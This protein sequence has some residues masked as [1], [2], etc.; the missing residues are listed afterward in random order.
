MIASRLQARAF[1]AGGASLR[2]RSMSF[3]CSLGVFGRVG[4]GV[5]QDEESQECEGF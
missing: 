5:R 3:C 2:S 4:R 1:S